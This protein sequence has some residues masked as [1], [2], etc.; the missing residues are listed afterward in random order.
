MSI[1]YVIVQVKYNEVEVYMLKLERCPQRIEG[2]KIVGWRG[3][4]EQ[5]E[6]FAYGV[7]VTWTSVTWTGVFMP[8]IMGLLILGSSW[9]IWVYPSNL[10]LMTSRNFFFFFFACSGSDWDFWPNHFEFV[11]L[12]VT[13]SKQLRNKLWHFRVCFHWVKP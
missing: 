2:G 10:L 9:N 5:M 6:N 13:I 3:V 8:S 12:I 1:V 4:G 7:L 11:Y